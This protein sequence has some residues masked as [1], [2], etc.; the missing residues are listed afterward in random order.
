MIVTSSAVL[1]GVLTTWTPK[2]E[3]DSFFFKRLS[4][5]SFNYVLS[6]LAQ[7]GEPIKENTLLKDYTHSIAT[8][9]SKGVSHCMPIS[10]L[11]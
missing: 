11:V 8:M 5:F 1:I 9:F 2:I 4:N 10:W 7:Q 3:N 6:I